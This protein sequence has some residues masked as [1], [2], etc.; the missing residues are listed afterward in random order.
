[1]EDAEACCLPYVCPICEERHA[2][3]DAADECCQHRCGECGELYEYESDAEECCRYRCENCGESY[4]YEDSARECCSRGGDPYYPTL[5]AVTP[6]L[7]SIDSLDNRVPRLLSIEEE[8]TAGGAAVAAVLRGFDLG[9]SSSI[10][11]YSYSPSMGG[12]A[13]CEDGSLPSDGGEVKYSRF[14]LS[15]PAVVEKLSVALTKIR[16]LHKDA[17]IVQVSTSAGMHIHQAARDIEG[18]VLEPRDMTALH[19][20]FCYGEDMI[21]GLAAAGWQR[22]RYTGSGNDYARPIPKL[23]QKGKSAWKVAR[24][25][26]NKYYGINFE[27]LLG[28]VNRCNCGSVRF[29][30]WSEC[31]C[32]AFDKATVGGRVFTPSRKPETIHAWVLFT[33]AVMELAHSHEI[34]TLVDQPF[35]S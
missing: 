18:R 29:G 28:T 25:M 6:Y 20:L 30:S 15:R 31:E 12:I 10:E 11:D 33:A 8:L 16:Q 35:V 19:E 3:E 5:A 34:G 26:G 17:G 22:H 21:Y 13:V 2:E 9:E 14:D 4:E 24:V 7:V 27:R 23:E 1:E 32:G